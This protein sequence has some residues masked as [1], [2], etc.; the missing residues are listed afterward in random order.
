M[1]KLSILLLIIKI[2]INNIMISENYCNNIKS[3]LL[4]MG[5]M[6]EHI[7]IVLNITNSEEDA[8]NL[9]IKMLENEEFYIQM[10]E[11]YLLS[12]DK[13]S[14]FESNPNKYKMTIV[15]RKDLNMSVGKIA[16]QVGHGVLKSYQNALSEYPTYVHN[17]EK[18]NGSTK[19]VLSVNSLQ[20]ILNIKEEATINKLPY[21][22]IRD[23]GRTEV[24]P[25][26]ITVIAIGPGPSEVVDKVTGKLE[27]LK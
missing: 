13:K 20:E 11:N 9:I 3:N 19:I 25:F 12:I 14:Y 15:V 27:L 4:D 16:A 24:D 22:L 10:K 6:E 18:N 1:Y 23:A 26:T 2:Y 7:N 8:I 17:W 21:E 5:F